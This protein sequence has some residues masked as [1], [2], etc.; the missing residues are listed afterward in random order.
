[1]TMSCD[2][3]GTTPVRRLEVFTG[4][5]RRRDWSDEAKAAIVEES[6]AGSACVSAVARRYALMPSQLFTW[7]REA[8]QAAEA[9]ALV[10][11]TASAREPFFVPAVIEPHRSPVA[12]RPVRGR[13]KRRARRAQEAAA[14]ELEIDGVAVKIARGADAG[15][16]AAV[17]DA[18]KTTR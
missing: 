8:R 5:G 13:R 18:L 16:I 2:D 9:A 7:R 17:I 4:A 3:A 1:M 6:Y 15:V 12:P 10:P 14:V 11:P